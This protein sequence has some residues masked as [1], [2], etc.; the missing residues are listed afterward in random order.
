MFYYYSCIHSLMGTSEQV[1]VKIVF[2]NKYL[3]EI[4]KILPSRTSKSMQAFLA[5]VSYLYKVNGKTIRP[6][7]SW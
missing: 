5:P 2:H 4:Y 1:N 7:E 6:G 3:I